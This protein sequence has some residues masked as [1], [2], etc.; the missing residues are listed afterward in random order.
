MWT[1]ILLWTLFL[2]NSKNRQMK[3]LL[4]TQKSNN[5]RRKKEHFF[6]LF[7]EI[8]L[9]KFSQMQ[10][11]T[12]KL[13]KIEF[14]KFLHRCSEYLCL[15]ERKKNSVKESIEIKMFFYFLWTEKVPENQYLSPSRFHKE[16]LNKYSKKSNWYWIKWDVFF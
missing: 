15:K 14:D 7:L 1:E 4:K 8:L 12:I 6:F 5:F 3:F 2:W 11:V 10:T 13:T 9:S 16:G